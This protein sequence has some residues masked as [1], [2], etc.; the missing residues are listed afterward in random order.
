MLSVSIT[1]Y[2]LGL[3]GTQKPEL[4][5][6]FITPTRALGA[7]QAQNSTLHQQ[8]LHLL[9]TQPQ[10]DTIHLFHS[11]THRPV[12]KQF[13]SYEKNPTY[14]QKQR[15]LVSIFRLNIFKR[16]ST[17]YSQTHIAWAATPL[18]SCPWVAVLNPLLT[19]QAPIP[20]P[21]WQYS[22]WSA[23]SQLGRIT[24]V[25][26]CFQLCRH[27]SHQPQGEKSQ[28]FPRTGSCVNCWDNNP[29]GAVRGG[30]S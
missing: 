29:R 2:L 19:S 5:L 4:H 10:R 13:Q 28:S 7:M 30:I 12:K 8:H 18:K 1:L 16:F 17:K 14:K 6:W 22:W 23:G 25:L 24:G 9:V 20:P 21:S 15:S 11:G 26:L 27:W 3:Q